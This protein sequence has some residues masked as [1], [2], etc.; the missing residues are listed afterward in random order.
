MRAVDV[1]NGA[2]SM[3]KRLAIALTRAP[4]YPL[5]VSKTP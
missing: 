1:G 5:A 4:C 3:D 2:G